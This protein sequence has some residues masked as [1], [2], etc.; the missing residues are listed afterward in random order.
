MPP[1]LT[2]IL[3]EYRLIIIVR[4]EIIKSRNMS[5]YAHML[6]GNSMTDRS[7]FGCVKHNEL[8]SLRAAVKRLEN[9]REIK[10]LSDSLDKANSR[11]SQLIE[12]N[13]HLRKEIQSSEEEIR[14]LKADLDNELNRSEYLADV[15]LKLSSRIEEFTAFDSGIFYKR[16]EAVVDRLNKTVNDLLAENEELM[17]Q[18]RKLKSQ[19]TKDSTNSS[20]PS[21]QRPNHITPPNNREKTGRNPGGQKGHEGHLRKKLPPT[22]IH[23]LTAP[24]GVDNN[25]DYYKTGRTIIKQLIRV[26]L[27]LEV[28]QYEAD[29][30]RNHRTRK[31]VH[32]AFPEGIVNDVE[33]DPGVCALI[34]LLH[35]HGNMSYDKIGEILSELSDGM[36]KPSKGMMADLEKKFSEK[37]EE[38]RKEIYNRMLAYPYMHIDGTTVRINGKNGQTLIETSPAGTLL[39]HTGV[40]GDEA[41]KGTP[42][43]EYNGVAVHDGES[44]FFHYGYRHQ[45]C[46]IH[47]ERYLKGSMDNEPHLTWA[48]FM[49]E[50][51]Q[52][53]IHFVK[54]EKANGRESLT[55]EE[56]KFF[57]KQYDEILRLAE[58]EYTEHPPNRKYYINGYNTMKRLE[59]R[60][61]SYLHFLH[62]L[63]IPYQNNP[64][65]L[66]ARKE[67]MH[68]KQSGGYRSAE[69]AQYHCDVLSVI[70]S[71]KV[72]GTGR[73]STLLDVFKRR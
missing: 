16:T 19:I 39:F 32:A 23:K 12:K 5:I 28:I 2:D 42:M 48:S 29:E 37:S 62:D 15:N 70:E 67:K 26:S 10:H 59:N 64:A 55:K 49:R 66:V 7:C 14:F 18:V 4:Q 6:K 63:S 34:S 57:E 72:M 69:Y 22:E 50:Y 38:D 1:L 20:I 27:K 47:E 13:E 31:K 3:S 25:P 53:L 33:Y 21:S 11:I 43:E 41:V 56:I 65:E 35:S 45:G 68:S 46:L 61:D 24:E 9:G 17:G 44:T 58:K 60:R 30:Y 36:L 52:E 73:Y 40:K 54:E 71:N 51:L 8:M